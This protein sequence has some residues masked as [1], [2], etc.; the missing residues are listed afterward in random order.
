MSNCVQKL[1]LSLDRMKTVFFLFFLSVALH[2]T[3]GLHWKLGLMAHYLSRGNKT[4][5]L[6]DHNCK[7]PR[8]SLLYHL[9]TACNFLLCNCIT[10][11]KQKYFTIC[12]IN[13]ANV[14]PV[15]LQQGLL[16]PKL[17]FSVDYSCH[18]LPC[19]SELWHVLLLSQVIESELVIVMATHR[20]MSRWHPL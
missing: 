1:P 12:Y 20:L 9:T 4:L 7:V 6:V 18:T 16:Y 19:P 8:V 10:S 13:K 2:S 3:T 14:A 17:L 15:M 11:L 5:D